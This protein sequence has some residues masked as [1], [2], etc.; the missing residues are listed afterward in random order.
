MNQELKNVARALAVFA[1]M[2]AASAWAIDS[3]FDPAQTPRG[4]FKAVDNAAYAKECGSCHF[5]YLP[6]MLP[7]RS[8]KA[9][10]ASKDHFGES[11]SLDA[12]TRDEIERY[13][14]ANAA[15]KTDYRGS[16]IMLYSLDDSST[17]TR[18]T[19]L[20]LFRQRHVVVRKLMGAPGSKVKGFANCDACHE[21]ASTGSF[22]YDHIVVP[23]VTKVIKPGSVF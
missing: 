5:T 17:P 15:D 21:N 20:P 10:M 7:A 14:V 8:W 2:D 22:A 13:L 11:L 4:G 6:G 12:G 19:H 9:V 1:L 23:G 16:E 3:R 18:I